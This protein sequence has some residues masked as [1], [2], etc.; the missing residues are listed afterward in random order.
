MGAVPPAAVGQ[1][2]IGLSQGGAFVGAWPL[3]RTPREPLKESQISLFVDIDPTREEVNLQSRRRQPV[4]QMVARQRPAHGARF[5]DCAQR[6]AMASGGLGRQTQQ[7]EAA[8]ECRADDHP[9]SILPSGLGKLSHGL[10]EEL[11]GKVGCVAR[12]GDG[13]GV[14]VLQ[15]PGE[16][17]VQP[18]PEAPPLLQQGRGLGQ[19]LNGVLTGLLENGYS[20]AIALAGDTPHLPAQFLSE[21]VRELAQAARQDRPGVVVGPAFD[22]GFY[23]LGLT[24]ETARRHGPS[25]RAI[26]ETSPMGGPLARHHLLDGLAAAGLEVHLLP[27][28]VDV[29]EERDL[30]LFERLSGRSPERPRADEGAPLREAYLHLTDRCGRDCPHCY[31]R[32]GGSSRAPEL[33]TREWESVIEQAAELGATTYSFIGGDPFLRTDLISLVRRV[34]RIPEARMRLF[35]ARQL[36]PAQVDLLADAAEGKLL[37]LLS[38][39]GPEETN[40]EIRGEGSYRD[41]LE[42][43]NRMQAA[44]MEVGV[45]TV[46]LA[47]VLSGLPRLIRDLGRGKIRRLHLIMPHERGRL[48]ASPALIPAPNKLLPALDA[49]MEA[50]AA[51][52][53]EIDN[54]SAWKSRLKGSRDLCGAGC[55]L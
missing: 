55:S 16:H 23:L 29:D 7:V 12:E 6:G 46:M 5:E 30:R 4:E 51:A 22:G 9:G 24:A 54:L 26:L 38:L 34:A 28:W 17:T 41:G 37:C 36:E 3:R 11:C 52:G 10:G 18:L 35:F 1:V 48:T 44:G 25:L 45:N 50:A 2:K 33:G 19:R 27:G 15:Q 42:T 49:A 43:L 40:E 13:R 8:V 21:A 53:I 39:D 14:P 31:A 20:S 47:P 32:L